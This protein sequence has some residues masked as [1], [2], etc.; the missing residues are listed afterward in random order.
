MGRSTGLNRSTSIV[1][2][3][4]GVK[5]IYVLTQ[6]DGCYLV[7]PQAKSEL[8]SLAMPN[9]RRDHFLN[10][11]ASP[12]QVHLW[13]NGFEILDLNT[14]TDNRIAYSTNYF[15]ETVEVSSIA[16]GDKGTIYVGTASDGLFVFNQDE[17]GGYS[18]MAERLSTFENELPSNQIQCLY[19]DS[20]NI[21]WVGTTEGVA[22]I[23]DGIVNNLSKTNGLAQKWWQK[24]LGVRGQAPVF[25]ESV[26]AITSWGGSML[27]GCENDLFKA[28]VVDNSLKYASQ[29]HLQERLDQP[30]ENIKEMLVDIDGNL[31]VAANQLLHFN[32]TTDQLTVVSKSH[33]FRG[34]GFLSL[35]EDVQEEKIW[36]GTKKGGLYQLSYLDPKAGIGY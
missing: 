4:E 36:V 27:F 30:L 11:V 31:W 19:R 12:K 34:D 26:Y 21:I 2:I 35:A 22:T 17:W 9:D 20:N 14:K 7:N 18:N 15:S 25:A 3:K 6:R 23:E 5:G 13:A 16:V 29:F 10:L 24:L 32:I 33:A 28:T 8:E 1:S